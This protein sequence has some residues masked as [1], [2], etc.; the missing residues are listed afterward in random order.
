RKNKMALQYYNNA[1]RIQP[2]STEAFY[3]RGLLYQNMGELEKATNDYEAILK[4]DR[5][6]AD[7]HYNLGYIDLAFKKDYNSAITH[8][9]DAIRINKQY[10]EA[11]YNR[12]VAYD[13]L[14]DRK[15]AVKDYRQAL[16]I[17]PT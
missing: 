3:N 11:F 12:G 10:A 9:T 15:S 2:S 14:G 17:V 7:A 8:F 4:L 16:N 6:Y 1:L 13:F 5:N